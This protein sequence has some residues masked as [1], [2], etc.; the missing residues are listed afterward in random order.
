MFICKIYINIYIIIYIYLYLFT[1][2]IYNIFFFNIDTRDVN[3]K[4]ENKPYRQRN[5]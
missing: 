4:S 2:N 5:L 1:I 3:Q